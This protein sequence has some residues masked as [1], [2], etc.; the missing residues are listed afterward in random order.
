MLSGKIYYSPLPTY[1]RLLLTLW[2]LCMFCP[3]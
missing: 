2:N 3:S 1:L